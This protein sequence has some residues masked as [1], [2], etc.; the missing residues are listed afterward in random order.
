ME[1]ATAVAQT[2]TN[3]RYRAPMRVAGSKKRSPKALAKWL[4]V[5]SAKAQKSPEDEGVSDAGEGAFADHFPLRQHFP[6][7][8]ADARGGGADGE[9][10]G[11][12]R[13]PDGVENFVQPLPEPRGGRGQKQDENRSFHPGCGIHDSAA[14]DKNSE[15]SMWCGPGP[16]R[17][18]ILGVI[19]E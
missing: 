5:T 2:A 7:E 16:V 4:T 15:C 1:T 8:V 10:G 14:I 17:I 6:Q 13:A 11:G 19:C 18:D 12:A 9:I 3:P